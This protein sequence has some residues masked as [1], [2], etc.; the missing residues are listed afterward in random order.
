MNINIVQQCNKID[1]LKPS[2]TTDSCKKGKKSSHALEMV[3]PPSSYGKN[4]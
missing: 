2:N 1:S 4:L 3:E